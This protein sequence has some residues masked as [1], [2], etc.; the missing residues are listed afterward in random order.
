MNG[1]KVCILLY[2]DDLIILAD[3]EK[4]FQTLLDLM[5]VWCIERMLRINIAE[6]NIV[7]FRGSRKKKLNFNFHYSDSSLEYKSDYKYLGIYLDEHL[8][9]NN[10]INT[11][12]DFGSKTLGALISKVKKI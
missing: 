6:S 10:C 7:H 9:F 2:A 8:T 12:G 5:H 11:L 4:D 1:Y 3:N